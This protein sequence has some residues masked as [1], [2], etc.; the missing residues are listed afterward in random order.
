M[1]VGTVPEWLATA[2]LA[3]ALATLGF[4][5]K[6]IL[7]WLAALRKDRRERRARLV[8]L[9][10]LLNGTA[11]VFRAQADLRRRLYEALASRDPAVRGLTG[12]EAIFTAAY[13]T[14]TPAERELHNLLRGYTISGLK[15]LNEAILAWLKADTEF[16]LGDSRN[17][18][19]TKLAHQLTALEAHLLMWLAKYGSW[20]PDTPSHALVY[21]ADEEGHGVP[22]P[23]G[24][25]GTIAQALDL[26][27][28]SGGQAG[29]G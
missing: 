22:F 6:Q 17:L 26:R 24:I 28:V 20:I 1:N 23:S 11:A 14:M 19:R 7:E 27:G 5:G 10:S 16:K 15:P 21:L 3:A 13:A 8:T 18:T 2:L 12:Y 29:H 9:L 4:V 25:E